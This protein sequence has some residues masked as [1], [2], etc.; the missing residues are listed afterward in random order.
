MTTSAPWTE[1]PAIF[2]SRRR[3]GGAGACRPGN[4]HAWSATGSAASVSIPACSAP[5]R[6]AGPRPRDL[7]T[8]R[9]SSRGPAIIGS[10]QDRKHGALPRHRGR[11]RSGDRR[12]SRRVMRPGRA[13][14]LCPADREA[15][16]TLNSDGRTVE[17]LNSSCH[18]R[19]HFLAMPTEHQR[20]KLLPCASCCHGMKFVRVIPKLG[21]LPE[22]ATFQC[23]N[24]ETGHDDRE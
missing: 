21:G 17:I 1:S 5:I 16:K 22:L 20:E 14:P 9:E 10:F 6:C 13:G 2:C 18:G 24:C 3:A 8:Q 12:A 7:P 4:M 11:R 23:P 19:R 15:Q